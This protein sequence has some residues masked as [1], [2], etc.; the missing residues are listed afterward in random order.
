MNVIYYF[1]QS[2]YWFV[3]F[4]CFHSQVCFLMN[5]K[6]SLSS[7]LIDHL[8]SDLTILIL[9]LKN[10][11]LHIYNVYLKSSETY[12]TVLCEFLIYSLMQLL[13]K[14]DEHLILNDFNLHHFW[15]KSIRCLIKHHMTNDLVKVV[16]KTELQLLILS[17]IIIWKNCK[18]AIIVNLIFTFLWLI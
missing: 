11:V 1:D 17:D 6:L 4:Q 5:K 18:S 12:N 9:Q 14:S 10:H 3:Y 8:Q 7:W 15:W 2:K 13:N 16:K